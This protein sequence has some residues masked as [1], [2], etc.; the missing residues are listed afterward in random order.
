MTG[1]DRE[2]GEPFPLTPPPTPVILGEYGDF[3]H[4]DGVRILLTASEVIFLAHVEGTEIR[5]GLPIE[6]LLEALGT[7]T[8]THES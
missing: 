7:Y 2:P 1:N 5:M 8:R 6:T 3:E 4:H